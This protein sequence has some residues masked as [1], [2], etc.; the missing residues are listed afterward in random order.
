MYQAQQPTIIDGSRK[1]SV[2]IKRFLFETRT[3]YNYQTKT[4]AAALAD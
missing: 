2:Y 4:A 3:K 1:F